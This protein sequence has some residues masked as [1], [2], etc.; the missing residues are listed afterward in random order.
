MNQAELEEALYVHISQFSV[1][2][3]ARKIEL[4]PESF[5]I[6]YAL[7]NADG[8]R[9]AYRA[10]W[11]C[12]KL[13]E[14]HPNWF[15]RFYNE[16][17]EKLTQCKHEGSRRLLLSILYNLPVPTNLP[18]QLLNYCFDHMLQP[19]ESIAVQAL[20]IK[21]AYNLCRLEPDLMNELKSVLENAEI[22]YYSPGVQAAIRN[23]LKN[24]KK[25]RY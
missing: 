10:L 11:V 14:K 24:I 25:S 22:D 8:S 23:T 20:S 21:N 4:E 16:P 6:L 7:A 19:Q 5:P 9:I 15:T 1:N 2:N 18:I 12:E 3:I 17:T 13:S